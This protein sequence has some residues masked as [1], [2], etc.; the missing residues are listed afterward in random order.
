[1]YVAYKHM[2]ERVRNEEVNGRT[3]E[4]ENGKERERE[5][6]RKIVVTAHWPR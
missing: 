6:E 2:D 5:R 1:M 3:T 4:G